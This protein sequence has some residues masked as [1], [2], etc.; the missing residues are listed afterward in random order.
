MSLA[1]IVAMAEN[2]VIGHRGR[3]P[4]HLSTDLRRFKRLTMGHH[5]LMGRKTFESLGRLLP[6]RTSVIMTRQPDLQ[7]PGALVAAD[8]DSALELCRAD[9]QVFVIGGGQ[10]YSLALPYA[11]RLYL[12]LV[13]GQFLGDTYFQFD[14]SHWQLVEETRFQASERD[15]HDHTFRILERVER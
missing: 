3:L 10:I 6:G 1:L 9:D 8:L 13:H 4:W 14:E 12:T 11:D 7:I 2:G 15:S 5:L